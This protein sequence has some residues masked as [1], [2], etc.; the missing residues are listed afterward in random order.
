MVKTVPAH[1][2]E[3]INLLIKIPSMRTVTVIMKQPKIKKKN[4]F[5]FKNFWLILRGFKNNGEN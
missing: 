4:F 2:V 3:K 1:L 5:N